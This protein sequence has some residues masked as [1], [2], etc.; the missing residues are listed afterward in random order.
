MQWSDDYSF[1]SC[2]DA[3]TQDPGSQ[4]GAGVIEPATTFYAPFGGAPPQDMSVWAGEHVAYLTQIDSP[5]TDPQVMTD[6]VA[7][8]DHAFEWFQFIT[9]RDPQPYPPTT[10]DGLDTIAILDQTGGAGFGYIGYTGIE[11]LESSFPNNYG[12]KLYGNVANGQFEHVPLYELGRNFYFYTPELGPIDPFM[13]GFA[14]ANQFLAADFAG[15]D[16]SAV[17]Y[18]LQWD[19]ARARLDDILTAYLA[20]PDATWQTALQGDGYDPLA[21]A[22]LPFAAT[23]GELA[24]AFIMRLHD[25]HGPDDFAAFW[26]TLSTRPAAVTDEDAKENFIDAALLATDQDY[27]YLFREPSTSQPDEL[28]A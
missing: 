3:P 9:G 5:F 15:L 26:Q 23:Q 6:L 22:G 4:S 2:G 11:I 14:V 16:I 25:D 1:Y 8:T 24:G 18:R 19:D 28:F 7:A 27:S 12:S 10:Y 20:D 13:N 17:N 21:I